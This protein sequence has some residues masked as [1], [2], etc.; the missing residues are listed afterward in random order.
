MTGGVDHRD[1]ITQQYGVDLRMMP[2]D[3]AVQGLLP[4]LLA[5]TQTHGYFIIELDLGIGLERDGAPLRG[6]GSLLHQHSG[7]RTPEDG[8]IELAVVKL[9]LDG[10]RRGLLGVAVLMAVA[11]RVV[12]QPVLEQPVRTRRPGEYADAQRV[13][14]L[15]RQLE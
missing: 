7:D 2:G 14:F 9:S 1:F 4:L 8:R 6:L 5:V 15:P 12:H 11:D 13:E 3:P 10:A